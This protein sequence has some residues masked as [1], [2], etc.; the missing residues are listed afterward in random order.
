MKEKEITNLDASDIENEAFFKKYQEKFNSKIQNKFWII[1]AFLV[2]IATLSVSFFIPKL[3]NQIISL[4]VLKDKSITNICLIFLYFFLINVS[5][6][7]IV[8]KIKN[9]CY[10]TEIRDHRELKN[11]INKL[12]YCNYYLKL[13]KKKFEDIESIKI[14]REK[15]DT[16]IKLR[17]IDKVV[18][19]K[20]SVAKY[21]TK[22]QLLPIN[23]LF[24]LL[25]L[26]NVL[27]LSFILILICIEA[28]Y[29]AFGNNYV[30]YNEGPIKGGKIDNFI[31]KIKICK[32]NIP[33][34]N[35]KITIDENIINEQEILNCELFREFGTRYNYK[36][37]IANITNEF[38]NIL[39]IIK[40][41]Y[42][43]DKA[44]KHD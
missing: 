24:L 38:N 4:G 7:I 40:S 2:L 17:F 26:L 3:I 41:R 12:D 31:K 11:F 29:D 32:I 42:S 34:V 23:I 13:A 44:I 15:H 19:V 30:G 8:C 43:K 5:I 33:I 6:L 21:K 1:I 22:W 20:L 28:A 36:K 9:L 16:Y 37:S 18:V 27:L 35:Q 25:T 10:G 39:D 14:N